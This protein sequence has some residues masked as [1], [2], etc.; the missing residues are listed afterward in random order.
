M[1]FNQFEFEEDVSMDAPDMGTESMGTGLEAQEV[2]DTSEGEG[3]SPPGA[4]SPPDAPPMTESIINE[5]EN[6]T[7]EEEWDQ[8]RQQRILSIL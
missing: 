8:L 7:E 5:D 4:S 1:N 2:R 6:L 3:A